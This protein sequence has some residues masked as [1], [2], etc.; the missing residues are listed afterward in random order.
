MFS[1]RSFIKSGRFGIIFILLAVFSLSSCNVNK[2]LDQEKGERLLVKNT[3]KIKAEKKLGISAKSSLSS[4]LATYYKQ[5]PNRK[6]MLFFHTRLWFWYKY[7]NRQSDF[8]KWINK[9][10]A[11]A[12]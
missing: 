2:F 6:N 9:R 4:E 5:K 12:P 8:A 1:C 10:I 7:K 3:L 11:E